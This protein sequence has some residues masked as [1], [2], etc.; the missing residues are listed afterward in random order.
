MVSQKGSH[1]KFGKR[2]PEGYFVAVVPRHDIIA[3]GT[4]RGILRH[5]RMEWEE[6]ER[7]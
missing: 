1:A 2:T 5:C 6:F 3:I 4:L 7:L